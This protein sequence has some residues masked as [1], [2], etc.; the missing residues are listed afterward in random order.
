MMIK[1]VISLLINYFCNFF[2][3]LPE[4]STDGKEGYQ[5]IF[6]SGDGD[7]GKFN[8]QLMLSILAESASI[9]L[10]S[11]IHWKGES[12]Y[13]IQ[14]D[15]ARGK[16]LRILKCEILEENCMNIFQE[17]SATFQLLYY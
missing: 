13:V 6:D 2:V 1:S 4:I 3:D 14:V 11:K 15:V 10:A 5:A 16:Q 17:V 8:I 9:L 7:Q 12:G